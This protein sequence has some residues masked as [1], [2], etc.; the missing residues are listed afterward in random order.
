MRYFGVEEANRLIPVLTRTFTRV[1]PFVERVHA[2]VRELEA[3]QEAGAGP[4]RTAPL[5]GERDAL[6]D[7]IQGELERFQDLGVELK[8]ADGLVDFRALKDG[9]PVYLCWRFG[10]TAVTHWH[11]L[12]GGFAGRQPIVHADEF[13]TSY[14]S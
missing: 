9:R 8:A 3:L 5:R 2:L 13:A 7:S 4:E 1:R 14:L 11:E 10:E 6:I 12:E